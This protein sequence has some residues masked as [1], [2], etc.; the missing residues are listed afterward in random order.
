M[1]TTIDSLLPMPNADADTLVPYLNISST[2]P[3]ADWHSCALGLYALVPGTRHGGKPVY[4]QMG[5]GLSTYK[6]LY[7]KKKKVWTV[8]DADEKILTAKTTTSNP[9]TAA[10]KVVVICNQDDITLTV[11]A[12][13]RLPPACSVSIS[14]PSLD[15]SASASANLLHRLL[16]WIGFTSPDPVRDELLLQVMGEYA[17][18]DQYQYGRVVYKKVD[19]ELYL[20]VRLNNCGCWVVDWGEG[21]DSFS[22]ILDSQTAPSLCPAD[23]QAAKW[24]YKGHSIVVKCLIH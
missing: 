22:P 10:W 14:C 11:A 17:A 19:M 20:S 6:V 23:P 16:S 12:M 5:G 3:T 13:T 2:G 4:Q 8:V 21:C 9:T 1:M 7:S 18:T 24:W 15:A